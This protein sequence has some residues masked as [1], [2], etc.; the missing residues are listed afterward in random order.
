MAKAKKTKKK[1]AKLVK[2]AKKK[3]VKAK[4]V[5]KAKKKVKKVSRKK[6]VKV[7]KKP[8]VPSNYQRVGVITHFFPHVSAGVIKIGKG[9]LAVGDQIH[10]KGATTDLKQPVS[11][12]EINHVA[13]QSVKK[14]DDA[15]LGTQD[16][17]RQGD[18]VYRVLPE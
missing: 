18:I 17:V 15:G 5:K 4:K 8:E 14:G 10:I 6:A 2:K 13:V 16:R 1:K 12:L 3:P 9:S 11:S 7:K